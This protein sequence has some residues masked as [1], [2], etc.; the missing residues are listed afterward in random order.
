MPL[1]TIFQLYHG[2][3]IGEG[4]RSTWRKPPTCRKSLDIEQRLKE[5]RKELQ[6]LKT[7]ASVRKLK[8]QESLE[9]QKVM[10]KISKL[11]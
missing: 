7:L 6:E 9:A 8:L 5:L 1:L 3:F 4:N 10:I 2:S 11:H